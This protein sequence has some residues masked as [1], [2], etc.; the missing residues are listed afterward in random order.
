MFE[1]LKNAFKVADLRKKI[2]LTLLILLIYRV[3]CWLPIPGIQADYFDSDSN[4]FL[5]LLSAVT[6]GALQNGAF[7]ALGVIPY[8]S[9]SI[10]MQ[11]LTFGIPSLE[12]LSKQGDA[13]RKK[14]AFY[15]R[16]ATLVL[17]TMQGFGIVYSL[18]TSE[19]LDTTLFGSG[20]P[21]IIV[22]IVVISIL[23]AGAMFTMWLGEKITDLG[24][25]NGLSLLVFIGIISSAGSSLF[26]NFVSVFENIDYLWDILIFAGLL[27]IIFG[28]ITFVDL[29]VR[30]IPVQY[31]KQIRGRKMYGGQSTNIPIK[32]NSFGVMPLIFATAFI[33]FPQYIMQIFWSDSSAYTWYST[34]LG[35][36]SIFYFL[37]SGLLILFFSYFYG[38]MVF[39]PEEI[40]RTLQQNGGFIPGKRAGKPTGDYIRS[41]SNR[42]TFFGAMYL[43]LIFLIPSVL[44]VSLGSTGDLLNAFSVTG[45]LIVVSVAL[46]FDKQIGAQMMM[47][48]YKGFLK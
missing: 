41:I 6:G 9:A 34:W 42:I 47:K 17:A 43:T 13:G 18:G 2:L 48:N 23:I 15:T 39:N 7:L 25:G 36:D 4:S 28:M 3:G 45:M 10:I 1:T 37:V 21:A 40:S 33:M 14:I 31:A 8:I 20:T 27:V 35:T 46:E 38:S 19:V 5:N 26:T 24:I 16:I 12:R 32:V 29:S 30:N 11:L 22:A 44:F